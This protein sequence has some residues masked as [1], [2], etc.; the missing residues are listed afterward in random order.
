MKNPL[1]VSEGWVTSI[2][3]DG[4]RIACIFLVK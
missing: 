3:N 2:K 1:K 4:R